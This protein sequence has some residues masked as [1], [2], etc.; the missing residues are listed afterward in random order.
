MAELELANEILKTSAVFFA[1]AELDRRLRIVAYIDAPR[2]R[3]GVQPICACCRST[4]SV[5]D[6]ELSEGY[7]V[8]A[9]VDLDQVNWAVNGIRKLWHAARRTGHEVGRDQVGRLTG[10]AG[11]CG[12]VRGKHRI[13]TTFSDRS[14]PRHPDLVKRGWDV[15]TATDQLWMADCSYATSAR[16]SLGA[17]RAPKC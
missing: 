1:Q 3:L 10:I 9:L 13:A 16:C 2:D 17:T 6:A 5:T 8:N 11:I 12:A 14:A 4:V 15:P 7:L